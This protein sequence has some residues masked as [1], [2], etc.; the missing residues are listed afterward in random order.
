VCRDF[1]NCPRP[2]PATSLYEQVKRGENTNPA[3]VTSA[4]AED[5]LTQLAASIPDAKEWWLSK[6]AL[7][8]PVTAAQLKGTLAQLNIQVEIRFADELVTYF[9]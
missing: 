7:E 6:F 2:L 9:T 3:L 5:L 8:Q 4:T 1:N